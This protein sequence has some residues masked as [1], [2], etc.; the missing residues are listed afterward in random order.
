MT[1]AQH[2]PIDENPH[3]A[4]D[5][6]TDDMAAQVENWIWY[7]FHPADEIDALIDEGVAAGDG[8]DVPAVKAFA[9]STIA[10]KR[11]TEATWSETTDCDKLDRAFARLHEQGICAL[12]CTGDTQ[13]DGFEA[14]IEALS[15]DGVPEDRYHG[16]C[17]YVSQDIDHALDD[18]GLLLAFGHLG[19]S[20]AKETEHVA[21]GQLVCEA[22]RQEG[23][24]VAWN[25][26]SR[27]RIALP[28]LSWQR[29][30]PG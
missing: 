16:Y 24:E 12:H 30:T 20:E 4:A 7:G 11:S 10:K 2:H 5:E 17:F 22:L 6:A 18:E 1:D 23:L 26:S 21:A 14:V 27:C 13:D 8:F 19:R 3:R 28:Q 25:G 29:R 9:A 15:A